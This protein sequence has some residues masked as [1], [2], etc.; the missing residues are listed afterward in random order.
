MA[1]RNREGSFQNFVSPFL[2]KDC[3]EGAAFYPEP[4]RN[5]SEMK[6]WSLEMDPVKWVVQLLLCTIEE[7]ALNNARN[8]AQKGQRQPT[9]LI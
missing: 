4:C 7:L 1:E 8:T 6:M 3:T 5:W 9:E 2:I